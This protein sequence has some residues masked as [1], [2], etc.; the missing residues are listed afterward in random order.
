MPRPQTATQ[1]TATAKARPRPLTNCLFWVKIMG[2]A[3]EAVS[4]GK[5]T[6]DSG[7]GKPNVLT[8]KLLIKGFFSGFPASSV[9]PWQ[10]LR[11]GKI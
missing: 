10:Q 9:A 3:A 2:C 4:G 6:R 5:M 7:V 11:P 8:F 1:A